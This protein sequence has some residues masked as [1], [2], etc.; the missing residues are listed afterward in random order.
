MSKIIVLKSL[1]KKYFNKFVQD[2]IHLLS[3]KSN[4]YTNIMSWLVSIFFICLMRNPSKGW[5]FFAC[6]VNP[7]DISLTFYRFYI[8]IGIVIDKLKNGR[9]KYKN[10]F[11]ISVVFQNIIFFLRLV[12]IYLYRNLSWNRFW[13][14]I[15]GI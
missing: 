10:S 8:S 11:N 5:S 15:I 1:R 12:S 14:S 4:N 13:C 2:V 9:N 7:K 3:S 6:I